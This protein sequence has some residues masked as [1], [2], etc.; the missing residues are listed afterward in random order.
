M[1]NNRKEAELPKSISEVEELFSSL[2][3]PFLYDVMLYLRNNNFTD[4]SIFIS[5]KSFVVAGN[6]VKL[7]FSLFVKYMDKHEYYHIQ[8]EHHWI[9]EKRM[10]RKIEIVI[11][12]NW[13][14][15]VFVTV[16]NGYCDEKTYEYNKRLLEQSKVKQILEKWYNKRIK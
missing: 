11:D 15:K 4:L 2:Y 13:K 14:V 16:K 5:E 8:P 7:T 10:I 3:H 9:Y 1:G 6:S 12:N